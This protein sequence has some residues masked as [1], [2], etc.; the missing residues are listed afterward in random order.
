MYPNGVTT[1]YTYNL[2]NRLTKV[3]ATTSRSEL[4]AYQYALGPTGNRT[5]VTELS[6]HGVDFLLNL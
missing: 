2:L 5:G 1:T 6:A 3:A 4:G